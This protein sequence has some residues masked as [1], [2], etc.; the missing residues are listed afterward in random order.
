M[1]KMIIIFLWVM[2]SCFGA[3]T[4]GQ[5]TGPHA[6]ESVE[7]LIRSLPPESTW[8]KMLKMGVTGDGIHERWMDEM[9]GQGVKLA[10]FEFEFR[11][12]HGGRKLADWSL[13][14]EEY[15]VDYDRTQSLEKPSVDELRISGLAITLENEAL[16]RAKIGNWLEYP[17]QQTG[18]GYRTIVLADNKWLPVRAEGFSL[19]GAYEPGT[20]PLMHAAKLGDIRRLERLLREG[21]DVNTA[22]PDGST[23]LVYA[24]SSGNPV[25]VEVLLKAGA[26]ARTPAGGEAL[27]TAAA[28]GDR[29]SLELLLK[30]GVDPNYREKSGAT[31]LSIA[32]QRHFGEIVKLLQQAGAQE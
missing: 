1:Q 2:V 10:I 14:D 30:A 31:P 32:S 4:P 11:W 27:I 29:A 19:F 13:V 23:A 8:R 3:S 24:A 6:Q 25:A 5:A 26:R 21:T 22:A 7:Q 20:T 17:S 28:E 18:T 9:R 15:F 12:M 16:T